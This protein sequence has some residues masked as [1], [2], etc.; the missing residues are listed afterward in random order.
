MWGDVPG[1]KDLLPV[2]GEAETVVDLL[3]VVVEGYLGVLSGVRVVEE[4]LLSSAGFLC[5]HPHLQESQK[6]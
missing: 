3:L 6:S 4:G 1:D 5:H 2:S